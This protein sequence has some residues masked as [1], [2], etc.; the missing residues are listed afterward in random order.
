MSSTSPAEDDGGA[1]Q[2]AAAYAACCGSAMPIRNS[3]SLNIIVG[4]RGGAPDR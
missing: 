3:K 2:F 4:A 1:N